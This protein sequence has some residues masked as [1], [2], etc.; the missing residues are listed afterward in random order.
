MDTSIHGVLRSFDRSNREL[1]ILV[2]IEIAARRPMFY[3]HNTAATGIWSSQSLSTYKNHRVPQN[4][5]D[6]RL[7]LWYCMQSRYT[8]KQYFALLY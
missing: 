6:P 2:G 5:K 1:E 7:E 4:I 8:L 3:V